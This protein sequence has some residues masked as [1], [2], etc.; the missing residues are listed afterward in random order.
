MNCRLARDKFKHGLALPAQRADDIATAAEQTAHV[1]ALSPPWLV[2]SSRYHS[3]GTIFAIHC[4]SETNHDQIRRV[5]EAGL[6]R[7]RFVLSAFANGG[8][9]HCRAVLGLEGSEDPSPNELWPIPTTRRCLS[10][11]V[12]R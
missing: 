2:S 1:A 5:I 11:T 4:L 6:T 7:P 8:R 12:R 9:L 3:S 10:T